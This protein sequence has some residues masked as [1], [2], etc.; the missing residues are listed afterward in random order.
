MAYNIDT[1]HS[2][3]E[4]AVKHMMVTTVKG[5]FTKFQGDV[6]ID[7]ATPANSKV[8]VTIETASVTTGDENRD[9]HLRSGDFFESEKYPTI[10]FSSK[11]VEPLGGEKY[12]VS[13]DFTMHGVTR[14]ISFD[15]TREGVTKNMQ[16]K[17]LHAFSANLAI[18]RKDFGL[19]WNVALESGGLLVSD[20]VKISL[21]V[22]AIEAA[23]V[24]A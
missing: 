2:L 14:A 15:I 23:T 5:R 20:Q 4:F 13:G 22:Q 16:G 17:T 11:T 7:E 6:E 3:I 10:T 1:S 21:E 24:A 18:S 19:E 8:D 9:G 12:R